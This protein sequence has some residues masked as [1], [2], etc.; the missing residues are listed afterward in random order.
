MKSNPLCGAFKLVL[1]DFRA[2]AGL[3]KYFLYVPCIFFLLSLYLASY[4]ILSRMAPFAL[5][6]EKQKSNIPLLLRKRIKNFMQ[7]DHKNFYSGILL[8]EIGR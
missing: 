6:G 3:K 1:V 7:R 5:S 2:V 8:L 4:I